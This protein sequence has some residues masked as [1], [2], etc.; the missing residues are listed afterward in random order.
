MK[1]AFCFTSD[2]CYLIN[3]RWNKIVSLL[4]QGV[5]QTDTNQDIKD[6]YPIFLGKFKS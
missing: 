3:T 2:S 5:N 4:K 6:E 1:L